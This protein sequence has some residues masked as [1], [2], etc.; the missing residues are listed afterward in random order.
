MKAVNLGTPGLKVSAEGLGCMGMSTT[1]GPSD[2]KKSLAVLHRAVEL[3]I[4]L[5]DTA[6]VYGP[7][8]NEELLGRAFSGLRER[9]VIAT[10]IG[11]GFTDEGKLK[12]VD[13]KPVVD[14]RPEHVVKAIEGSLR[15]LKTDYI[16][17]VY[18]HRIDPAIPIEETVSALSKL[19]AAGKIG[20]LGLSEAAAGT[21]RRAHAVH[22]ITAVQTEYSLFERS[23]EVNGVLETVRELGIG[24]VP[25]SPLGRGFLT[26]QLKLDQLHP[27]DF[28]NH[29]PRLNG[30]HLRT[31]IRIVE[32]LGLF[33][34]QRGV[35]PS[36]AALAWTIARGGV[37]IPGTRRISYLEEN[38]AAADIVLTQEELAKLDEVAPIGIASGD[39]YPE[40]N[41]S[42]LNR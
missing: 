14:G 28:R 6:E 38:A 34:E 5:F 25:Y 9:V 26:G 22:P 16:D 31:N 30:D 7:Y 27:T 12:I 23:I 19:V 40:G 20:H 17:L 21:I 13:G 1:Y 39:R 36:Q 41:M 11:F 18:L 8:H 33:A 10:K 15:R 29:D 37:P 32:A 42:L 4:T 2:D 3:G 24:F 35:K